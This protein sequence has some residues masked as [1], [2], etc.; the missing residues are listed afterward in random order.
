MKYMRAIQI[1]PSTIKTRS[2]MTDH[3]E[4]QCK[5][6]SAC[7]IEISLV[8][9]YTIAI[10]SAYCCKTTITRPIIVG[11]GLAV[12]AAGTAWKLLD[13]VWGGPLFNIKGV[14]PANK[15]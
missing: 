5:L 8:R 6:R 1:R 10:P 15:W 11:Q 9:V 14:L 4:K 3:L 7:P 13:F 2:F 12:L